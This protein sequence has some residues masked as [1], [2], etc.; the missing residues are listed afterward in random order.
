MQMTVQYAIPYLTDEL[1]VHRLRIH[2]AA[3]LVSA[4]EIINDDSDE[5]YYK[6]DISVDGYYSDP[7]ED[8]T[9][10]K[11][12][13]VRA[14]MTKRTTQTC[15]ARASQP[16]FRSILGSTRLR[17]GGYSRFFIDGEYTFPFEPTENGSC[18]EINH[19]TFNTTQRAAANA[20]R[21]AQP[22]QD[23]TRKHNNKKTPNATTPK[24]PTNTTAGS[25]KKKPV[26]PQ[27][28]N[29]NVHG[30]SVA[31]S[32]ATP[33]AASSVQ[34]TPSTT[35]TVDQAPITPSLNEE[36]FPE[37]EPS[38]D[39]DF[40]ISSSSLQIGRR[41]A[42]TDSPSEVQKGK[43]V[44]TSDSP[45]KVKKGKRVAT[46]EDNEDAVRHSKRQRKP[47][48]KS[49]KARTTIQEEAEEVGFGD[50]EHEEDGED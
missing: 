5:E 18:I 37:I 1:P 9:K 50:L 26:T 7:L 46:G 17:T 27:N 49:A 10:R 40:T 11:D 2:A 12:V 23:S 14:L 34:P 35:D 44:T 3:E 41:G 31:S 20:T 25:S 48:A 19:I 39:E 38:D 45:S 42:N 28:K 4:P 43:R 33:H 36:A 29:K 24:T 13:A 22:T 6:F 21:A 30:S 15:F 16:L 8:A 47:T 32:S